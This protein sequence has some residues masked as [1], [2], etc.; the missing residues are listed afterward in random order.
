MFFFWRKD[1]SYQGRGDDRRTTQYS[2]GPQYAKGA[3][4]YGNSR[5]KQPQHDSRGAW[6]LSPNDLATTLMR[7]VSPPPPYANAYA[8]GREA[9]LMPYQS[10][11]G[12]GAANSRSAKTGEDYYGRGAPAGGS[13]YLPPPRESYSRQNDYTAQHSRGANSQE[14][15]GFS[16]KADRHHHHHQQQHHHP[17]N[18]YPSHGG[19]APRNR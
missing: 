2:G 11:G 1:N 13:G 17:R 8:G 4:E 7:G 10:Y 6:P 12:R 9:D 14:T 5:Q 15:R 19:K 18:P 3:R 16:A